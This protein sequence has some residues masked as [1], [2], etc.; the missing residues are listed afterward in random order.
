MVV[1]PNEIATNQET[2][3]SVSDD[4][5]KYPLRSVSEEENQTIDLRQLPYYEAMKNY[6]DSKIWFMDKGNLEA[7]NQI[8]TILVYVSDV[9]VTK[10]GNNSY[11]YLPS[12]RVVT[13]LSTIPHG[14]CFVSPFLPEIVMELDKLSLKQVID[15]PSVY[16]IRV[17]PEFSYTC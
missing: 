14:A 3:L 11:Y 17:L 6:P 12:G 4:V 13:Q 16:C 5:S 2:S 7:A 15:N 8:M 1:T 10:C 9:E